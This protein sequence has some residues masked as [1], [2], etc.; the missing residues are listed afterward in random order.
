MVAV[1]VVYVVE[2]G[3][4]TLSCVLLASLPERTPF[5]HVTH[6]VEVSVAVLLINKQVLTSI[7]PAAVFQRPIFQPL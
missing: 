7:I 2:G 6:F 4:C 5:I 3:A 1:C